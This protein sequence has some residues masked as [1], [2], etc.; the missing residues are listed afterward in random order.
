MIVSS[1]LYAGPVLTPEVKVLLT[2]AKTKVDGI[3]AS[4][5]NK[6][7]GKVVLIDVRDPDEWDKSI[8]TT[9]QVHVS[10]GF[11]EIKYPKVILTKYSKS[12]SFV[13]YCALEPRSVLAAGRLKELGF[14]NV[15]YLIGGFK[16]WTQ[17]G[18]PIMNSTRSFK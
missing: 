14:T 15:R 17:E 13:V 1:L 3:T 4:E 12:D 2:N 9:K 7:I 5:V 8:E 11:L 10:R 16:N 6:L 18:Y